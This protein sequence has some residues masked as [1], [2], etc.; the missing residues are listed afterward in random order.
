MADIRVERRGGM[1]GWHWVVLALL[2]LALALVLLYRAGYIELPT[3]IRMG[4]LEVPLDLIE[5]VAM[6]E[7]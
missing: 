1:R 5:S 6:Q 7:A 2:V 3:Q 4:A